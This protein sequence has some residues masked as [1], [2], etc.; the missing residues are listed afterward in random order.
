MSA[1]WRTALASLILLLIAMAPNAMAQ[2]SDIWLTTADGAHKLE[3]HAIERVTTRTP[4][5]TITVDPATRY[6]TVVGFG[7]AF[8]DA[9][10]W[11]IRHDLSTRSRRA[12]MRELFSRRNRGLGLSF[13]RLTIGASDFS[14]THYSYDDA[15][16]SQRDID[17]NHFSIG[18]ARANLIP[19]LREARRLNPSL[20]IMASPW[21]APG[22]MK[23]SGH[24]IG[25]TLADDAYGP[26]AN[27]LVRYVEA[28]RSAGVPIFALTVQNEP[29][30]EPHDYPGMLLPPAA[31]ARLDADFL[32]P[33]L[34][35]HGLNIQILEFD[36]NWD[37]A[38]SPAAVLSDPRAARYI[39]GVAWHCYRGD[40]AA[41]AQGH[42]AFPDKD[43]YFTECS[44]GDWDKEFGSSFTWMMQNLMIGATRGW[45]RGVLL[46]NLAL[47]EHHGPH[48]G[49]CGDCRGVVT[50][51]STNGRITRNAEYYALAHMSRF[52]HSGAVR[53]GAESSATE[54]H[55]VAFRNRNGS[56][57]VVVLNMAP[58]ERTMRIATGASSALVVLPARATA[59]IVLR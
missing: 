15:R 22:W 58:A 28:M 52:V 33:Q 51:D 47:D 25:G 32:G 42:D 14:R 27:Y 17:L 38:Q 54:V 49:G 4:D 37:E 43:T 5:V 21:S 13:T 57:A 44:G 6:Q 35:A 18:P 50:I 55:T 48:L 16:E 11:T 53:I 46:W 2:Q 10:A 9:S 19:L 29:G 12:L 30:Y 24:M 34:Q 41:M 8:T 59:T 36:H 39:S 31:R 7:A 56:I 45:A 26:F 1:L 23:T 3:H 40:V 20:K